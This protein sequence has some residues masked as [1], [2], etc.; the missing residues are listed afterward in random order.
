MNLLSQSESSFFVST[1]DTGQS[2][3]LKFQKLY[4]DARHSLY[5]CLL[6]SDK[7]VEILVITL[8][9]AGVSRKSLRSK[10]VWLARSALQDKN[11]KEAT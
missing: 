10:R 3:K 9:L 2:S 11:G 4:E 5:F 1:S 8:S 6:L 7:N